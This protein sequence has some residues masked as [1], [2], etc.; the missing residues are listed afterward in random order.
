VVPE[1]RLQLILDTGCRSIEDEE[2]RNHMPA[3]AFWLRTA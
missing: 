3:E 2:R 1:K